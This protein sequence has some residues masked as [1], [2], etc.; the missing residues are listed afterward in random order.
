VP[1][2]EV[3]ELESTQTARAEYDRWKAV[4]RPFL[5]PSRP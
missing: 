5:K 1:V 3:S 4:Q 2:S